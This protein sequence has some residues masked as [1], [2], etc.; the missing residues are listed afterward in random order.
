MQNIVN[1]LNGNPLKSDVNKKPKG[2]TEDG[3]DTIKTRDYILKD[4]VILCSTCG[5]SCGQCGS[6]S[7]YLNRK[8]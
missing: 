1:S 6:G 7:R 3:R 5:S 8:W 4:N 2:M